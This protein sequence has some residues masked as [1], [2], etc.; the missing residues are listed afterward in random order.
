M[1]DFHTFHNWQKTYLVEEFKNEMATCLIATT[2]AR[3]LRHASEY[4]WDVFRLP[5]TRPT[6]ALVIQKH[7]GLPELWVKSSYT[8]YRKAFLAYLN[9]FFF[10]KCDKIPKNWQVDHLQ[11]KCRFK[12][13]HPVYFIRLHLIDRAINSSY[14][15]GFEK[16]FYSFER[17]IEPFGGIHMDWLVF[18]KAY[19]IRLPSKRLG[20]DEWAH[21]SWEVASS[22]ADSG[23]EDKILAYAGIST[24][25]NLGY[26]GNY[27]SLPLQ[28]CFREEVLN[29]PILS[30]LPTLETI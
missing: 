26:T 9:E 25:L 17:E 18:L 11:P 2:Q 30:T 7:G 12:Q 3:L 4:N 1:I 15:A 27:S 5:S 28:P 16:S 10:M 20:E 13:E 22:L 6:S 29:S 23:V 19:G 21:W 14:G 24:V 8:R